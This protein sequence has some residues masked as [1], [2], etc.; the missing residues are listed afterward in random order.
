MN[1]EH[2]N[3]VRALKDEPSIVNSVWCRFGIHRWTFWSNPGVLKDKWGTRAFF[4]TKECVH[5]GLV[6]KRR[7]EGIIS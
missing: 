3:T 7:I 6:A 5:C 2:E 1:I 4:Q